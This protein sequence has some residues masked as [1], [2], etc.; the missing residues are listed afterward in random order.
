MSTA[1]LLDH[2]ESRDIRVSLADG[3]LRLS[4]PS[5]ALTPELEA[6]LRERRDELV[7]FLR[8]VERWSATD[9]ALVPLHGRSTS[10]AAKLPLFAVP[11]HN[12]DVF[13]F[14]PLAR[15]LG[16]E[17]PLLAYQPPGVDGKDQPLEHIEDLAE[18]F[19]AE[20]RAYRPHGPY[21]IGGYCTGGLVAFEAALRLCAA[22]EEVALLALFGTS[23]PASYSAA[24]RV[25]APGVRALNH[26]VRVVRERLE[27]APQPRTAGDVV[28]PVSTRADRERVE[29][30]TTLAARRYRPA[31]YPG[32]LTLY[33]P[34]RNRRAVFAERYLDWKRHAAGG[35]EVHAG[36]DGT[37]HSRMLR[38]PNV[39]SVAEILAD[40]L[41]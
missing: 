4:A 28:P 34:S 20:V 30:A 10:T 18:R 39:R 27:R 24:H 32:R 6:Q 33:I 31:V 40:A 3:R 9:S 22:G 35:L 19:V 2:L 38:E 25:Y 12:G 37:I 41:V 21:R 17:Q 1:E 7:A 26:G 15:R 5:G 8:G 14:V 29:R 13:C 16:S 23:S 36:A 11:G